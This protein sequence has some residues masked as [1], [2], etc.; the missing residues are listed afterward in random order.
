MFRLSFTIEQGAVEY[1]DG[2]QV[3]IEKFYEDTIR[4]ISLTDG[5]LKAYAEG[6]RLLILSNYKEGRTMTGEPVAP[7]A[8]YTIA[9]KGHARPFLDQGILFKSIL[10]QKVPD[11][12]E[13]FV[14]EQ[15][16][17]IAFNL[18]YGIN[19]AGR[20]QPAR[21][22][23]GAPPERADKVL[24]ELLRSFHYSTKKY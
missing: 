21:P 6:I 23:F 15:R 8:P 13:I 2:S 4:F 17:Q 16:A 5:D 10:K 18:Q 7:L 19:T 12:W 9:K 1:K 24:A 14:A 22:A 20:P 3:W 11:G